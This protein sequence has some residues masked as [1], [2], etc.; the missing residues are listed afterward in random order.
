MLPQS[1]TPATT[2]SPFE[3]PRSTASSTSGKDRRIASSSRINQILRF[4]S[5]GR[6]M[7]CARTQATRSRAERE[8]PSSPP[9]GL[10]RN[11]RVFFD[12]RRKSLTLNLLFGPDKLPTPWTILFSVKRTLLDI[13]EA[14]SFSVSYKFES[15]F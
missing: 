8:N 9:G 12:H 2:H 6:L 4:G 10:L 11:N 7:T 1:C 3:R 5:S 15:Y 13:S 14:S